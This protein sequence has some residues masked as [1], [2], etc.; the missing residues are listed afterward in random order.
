M[1]IRI[2][3]SCI[4]VFAVLLSG[5]LN[6]AKAQVS[7][8]DFR[9]R[10]FDYGYEGWTDLP[11]VQKLGDT[12]VL[13]QGAANGGVGIFYN[14]VLD[15]SYSTDLLIWIRRQAGHTDQTLR[16]KL[17]ASDDTSAK[18]WTIQ[19]DELSN[20]EVA[21]LQLPFGEL[22]EQALQKFRHIKQLQIQGSFA[23]DMKVDL[24]IERIESMTGT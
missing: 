15:L 11:A 7:L 5:Q 2:T 14:D 9:K 10:G 17:L 20:S 12:G 13:I 4:A 24:L 23:P 6:T 21:V 19:A 22:D 1:N 8:C 18:E 3:V 16:I